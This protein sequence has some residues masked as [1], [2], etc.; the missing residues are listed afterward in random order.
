MKKLFAVSIMLLFA[1]GCSNSEAVN[2]EDPIGVA[3]QLAK[4]VCACKDKEC[5]EAASKD[6]RAAQEQLKK[7][8]DELKELSK[9][10]DKA[11]A[12]KAMSEA[13]LLTQHMEKAG[14]CIKAIK[15][16]KK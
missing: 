4:K 16:A 5:V 6:G 7:K 3:E 11:K 2:N 14:G 8:H 9:S 13:A 1:I 10:E 15:E 12:Q